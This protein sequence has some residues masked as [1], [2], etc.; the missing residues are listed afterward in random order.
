MR[1]G[2]VQIHI[3]A[4]AIGRMHVCLAVHS[5]GTGIAGLEVYIVQGGLGAGGCAG[6]WQGGDVSGM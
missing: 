3:Y 1:R 5:G 6:Q 2:R 4:H